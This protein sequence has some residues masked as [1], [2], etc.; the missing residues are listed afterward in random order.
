MGTFE[1][2]VFDFADGERGMVDLL[3]GKGAGLAEMTAA[4]LPVP[5]GFVITTAACR[6]YNAEGKMF[7]EN[8]WTQSREALRRLEKE[9]G[10]VFGD[11]TD[12]LL[13]SVRSGAA[14]SMPGM[15]DTVLNLGLNEQSVAGLTALTGDEHFAWDTYRRFVQ[16]FGEIVLGVP[17]ERLAAVRDAVVARQGVGTESELDVEAQHVLVRRYKNVLFG[18]ARREMPDDPEEQ[19][20]LAI[21]AVF[22]SWMNRR[23]VDYRR[24]NQISDDI[25][26]AVTVQA[27]VFGNAGEDSGTGVAF[28]R[29]P[30]T[31]ERELY[32]EFLRN[33]QG[34]DVVAGIR[35]PLPI[36]RMADE[37]PDAH[38]QLQGIATRLE[39]HYRDMQD[40][41]FTVERGKLWMLQTRSGKRTGRAALRIAVDQADDGVITPAEAVRRLTAEQLEQTL[42]RVI[43]PSANVRVL[44]TGLPASPGAASGRVVLD[45]DTAERLA[46]QGEAV[47]L[48]RHETSPDDFHGMV[49]AE[50]TVTTR[51]GVTSHAAVVARGMG[52]C[53]VVGCDAIEVDYGAE[54]LRIGSTVISRG[55]WVTVD[56]ATGRLLAG[57]V[58]TVEPQ[59]DAYF[60]RLMGWADELR[61]LRV[62]AN[63][64]TPAD[65][66]QARHLGAEGIGLCRT[67]HMFFDPE[68]ITAMR[69]MIMAPNAIARAEA[70]ARLEPLQAT[71]FEGIFEAMDGQPVTIRLLDP[72]LHEFL[73][74][75]EQT[76]LEITDLKLA[77][78]DAHRLEDIDRLLEQIHALETM[79]GQIE[80]LA[81]ANPMLGHRGCRLGISFPQI[82]E[83]QARAVFTAA[84]RC[85]Q[86]GIT[87]KPE[88]MIPLVAFTEEFVAQETIVR[89]IAREVFDAHGVEVDYLVGTMVEL[90]RA[91]LTADEL[92]GSA[93][94][95]SFGTND[96]TQTALGLSR[97]DSGRF[98][99]GYV[100]RDILP[101]DPFQSLDQGGVGQLVRI[102]TERGRAT[103][104]ELHVGICGEHGG[105]PASIAF[106]HDVGLDY[107]SCSPYRVPI[108]RLAAAQAALDAKEG[109]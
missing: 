22:D 7:P 17:A 12:P 54:L 105:D 83:M 92:A 71:D 21:A 101:G 18:H 50:A 23:A 39:A 70:L 34:E 52:K 89:R 5:P 74:P 38:Q 30:T 41:E 75:H 97:D 57:K 14:V 88:I 6:A 69:D 36:T 35:T 49:A 44:A 51:G 64:E 98:L 66:E 79:L 73:P 72:P 87:V 11:P 76:V 13:V 77:L 8:M 60:D 80:R 82:T 93:E 45:A 40:L 67:E 19:L 15:M 28:T 100:T 32:G 99:P 42:H 46:G 20:R 24:L 16:M 58:A 59:L 1:R 62:R 108:A 86:R 84:V 85:E 81:E 3:G 65:A 90:P 26:T 37:L 27:M 94:F 68:R 48:V 95:F 31:G 9:T 104:P 29:N 109:R 25:G 102:G 47:V 4:G 55:D 78:R 63:A 53:C 107:V 33:A 10:K 2:W 106:F 96:L 61:T 103:R 91:A 56:G 43:D